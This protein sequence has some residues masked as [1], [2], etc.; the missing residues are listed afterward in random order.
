MMNQDEKELLL[1]KFT[2]VN[3]RLMVANEQLE[4]AHLFIVGSYNFDTEY[5]LY[6]FVRSVDIRGNH[7]CDL[8]LVANDEIEIGRATGLRAEGGTFGSKLNLM[9]DGAEHTG[10]AIGKFLVQ[11]IER[12]GR[13]RR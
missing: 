9:K 1:Q 6:L 3:H 11:Q 2:E 5:T 7:D 8:V 12:G 4:K 13:R 10:K